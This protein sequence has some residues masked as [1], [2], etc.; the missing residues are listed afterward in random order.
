MEASFTE[1]KS[2]KFD[3]ADTESLSL[4]L[5][6]KT[7]WVFAKDK[8]QATQAVFGFPNNGSDLMAQLDQSPINSLNVPIH[9][10]THLSN[11]VLV[12]GSLYVK[13]EES[14]YLM[15]SEEAEGQHSFASAIQGGRMHLV[16][17]VSEDLEKAISNRFNEVSF[18]HGG[19][20]FLDFVMNEKA[21]LLGQ[22]VILYLADNQMYAAC[23]TDQELVSFGVFDLNEQED[24]IKYPRALITQHGYNP[25]HARVNVIGK[26]E[27]IDSS[28]EWGKQFFQHYSEMKPKPNQ[29]LV[30]G[31]ESVRDFGFLEAFWQFN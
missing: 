11:F 27:G 31:L 29:N 16:G 6:P 19:S 4:F 28:V 2:D 24:L 10:F 9:L 1:F 18:H 17:S 20:S 21:N 7:I 26:S 3:V 8:N 15:F 22:E 23:F 12:P 5:Y 13:G 14:N 30:S 25:I